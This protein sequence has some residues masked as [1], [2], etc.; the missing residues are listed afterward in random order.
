MGLHLGCSVERVTL[1][2]GRVEGVVMYTEEVRQPAC[3]AD[4]A[5]LVRGVAR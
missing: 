3:E 1:E 4:Y 2:G 5:L